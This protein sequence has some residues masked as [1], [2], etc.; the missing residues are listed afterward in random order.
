MFSIAPGDLDGIADLTGKTPFDALLEAEEREGLAEH[1]TADER[2]IRVEAISALMS[3]IFRPVNNQVPGPQEV[4]MRVFTLCYSLAPSLIGGMSLAEIGKLFGDKSR[5]MLSKRLLK[6][7]EEL[8]LRSRNRKSETARLTYS[9][10]TTEWHKAR[11]EE[12]R[13]IARKEYNKRYKTEN[14]GTIQIANQEYYRSNRARILN[15]QRRR[16]ARG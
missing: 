11:R 4:A 1:L 10:N 15:Q 9:Q 5:Q 3:F 7:D 14:R 12:A 8:N 2:A 16:R 6:S 13:R